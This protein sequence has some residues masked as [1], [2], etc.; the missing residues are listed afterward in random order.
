M[1]LIFR[2][3][4]TP[5]G[6]GPPVDLLKCVFGLILTNTLAD[7]VLD[8]SLAFTL[9]RVTIALAVREVSKVSFKSS[10]AVVVEFITTVLS[11]PFP[12]VPVIDISITWPLSITLAIAL[13][14][15]TFC[16]AL[17]VVVNDIA[18]LLVTALTVKIFVVPSLTLSPGFSKLNFVPVPV[19]AVVV[20]FANTVPSCVLTT[21][22][23]ATSVISSSFCEELKVPVV[24]N[25][26]LESPVA[27]EAV[28]SVAIVTSKPFL[29]WNEVSTL[30]DPSLIVF[31]PLNGNPYTKVLNV[32]SSNVAFPK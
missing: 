7:N 16:A 8:A 19:T 10:V 31:I 28:P 20:L 17:G 25:V 29:N 21:L 11:A 22:F 18:T 24:V 26:W 27:N 2:P 3:S 30:L 32:G 12:V 23:F 15:A 14:L 1:F 5:N 9:L 13:P 6:Y 4:V